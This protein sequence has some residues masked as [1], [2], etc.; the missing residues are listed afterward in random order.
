LLAASRITRMK[1]QLARECAEME[2]AAVSR[3]L[4][5]NGMTCE[6]TVWRERM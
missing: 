3:K 2:S 5:W 4:R 1:N 6:Q